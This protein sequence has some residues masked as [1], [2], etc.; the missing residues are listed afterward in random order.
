MHQEDWVTC[1]IRLSMYRSTLPI[2]TH[3]QPVTALAFDPVSDTLWSGDNAG[4]VL[5]VH[6]VHAIRGVSFP[7]GGA[8]PV[9]HIAVADN[10]LRALGAAGLGVGAWAKGGVNK[11]YY[12]PSPDTV[13]AVSPSTFPSNILAAATSAPD[14]VL[15]NAVTGAVLRQSPTPSHISHLAFSHS[16]LLAAYA[17]G[18]VR[19]HDPRTAMRRESADVLAHASGVQDLQVSGNFFFS[20]GWS[21]RYVFVALASSTHFI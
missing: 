12:R 1:E 17:D 6:S 8:L 11:W 2:R 7:V 3:A 19:T 20:I 10:H 13:T 9:K 14:I 21:S 4:T 18:Y 5:A 15:L 16:S